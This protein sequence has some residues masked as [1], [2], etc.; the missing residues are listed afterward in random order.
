MAAA[1]PVGNEHR[2][3]NPAAIGLCDFAA[4]PKPFVI[5]FIAATGFQLK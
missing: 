1:L 2:N 3:V 4:R 5:P